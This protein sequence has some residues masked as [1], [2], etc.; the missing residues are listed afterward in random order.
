MSNDIKEK[1]PFYRNWWLWMSI[2]IIIIVAFS[3]GQ[4]DNVNNKVSKSENTEQVASA[5]PKSKP[6][7]KFKAKEETENKKDFIK[8]G[9]YKVG[10]DIKAG[11]YVVVSDD[12][13]MAYMQVSKDSTGSPNSIIC[14]DV[15]QN[16]II[17]T[18][19]EGEYFEVKN[20]KI[21]SIDKA[22]KVEPKNNELPAGMYKIGVEIQPGEY[23]VSSIN[24][25][26]YIEVAKDSFHNIYSIFSNDVFKGEKYITVK[27]G[28][29]L[30]LNNAK[31][32]LK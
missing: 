13:D 12:S 20:A 8:A 27:Q 15:I 1:K 5:K 2:V 28:Q 3:I 30:K 19:K 24:D 26:G 32:K 18:V 9:M 31:I 10:T 23:K 14:N 4:S 7:P 22:P 25:M 11:E 17:V 21:Y 29:Y 6:N 16:R